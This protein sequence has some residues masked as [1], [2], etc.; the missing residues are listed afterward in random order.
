MTPIIDSLEKVV[1]DRL[2]AELFDDHQAL[3]AREMAA[4]NEIIKLRQQV[5]AAQI[6][7]VANKAAKEEK[8]HGS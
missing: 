6:P 3:S 1:H 2:I 5:Y 4:R 7:S 8:K